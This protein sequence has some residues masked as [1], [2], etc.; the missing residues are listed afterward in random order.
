M[1]TYVALFFGLTPTNSGARD[2]RPAPAGC[3]L[4]CFVRLHTW[5]DLYYCQLKRCTD[6]HTRL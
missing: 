3:E 2:E 1:I 4:L 6:Q 5:I